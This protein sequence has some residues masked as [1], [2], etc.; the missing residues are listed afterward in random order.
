MWDRFIVSYLICPNPKL[1]N[2]EW[3]GKYLNFL[4]IGMVDQ[5]KSEEV[6][7]RKEYKDSRVFFIM[8]PK[9][10]LHWHAKQ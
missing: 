2:G 6:Q 5:N 1:D 4:F 3:G 9:K 10:K 8:W 7:E